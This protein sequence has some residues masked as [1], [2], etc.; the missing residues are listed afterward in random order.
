MGALSTALPAAANTGGG[1]NV[2][3]ARHVVER[4][5]AA[6]QPEARGVPRSSRV[7]PRLSEA[8]LTSWNDPPA[9]P[10]Y[11]RAPV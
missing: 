3:F 7:E 9:L 6:R 5:V 4:L 1:C 11:L 10:E 8:V 2:A